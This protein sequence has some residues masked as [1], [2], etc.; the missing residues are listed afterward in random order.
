MASPRSSLLLLVILVVAGIATSCASGTAGPRHPPPARKAVPARHAVLLP[1]HRGA[2]RPVPAATAAA[3]RCPAASYGPSPSAPGG[4]RTVALTFDDGPGRTTAE[5]LAI[6]RR[7]HVPATFFNIGENE[8]DR[9]S[10]VGAEADAGEAIG[11]HTW[12]HPDMVGLSAG[13]QAAELD[14]ATGEQKSIVGFAP[15]VFRPPYNDYDA[16]RRQSVPCRRSFVSSAP[17]ATTSCGCNHRTLELTRRWQSS[18]NT[19]P[20]EGG[21]AL[22]QRPRR[23]TGPLHQ[24]R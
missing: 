19:R 9:R 20:Q 16:T 8:A 24:Q 17:T 22:R 15:C 11:N 6:L 4:G 23:A 5:V 2:N 3:R 10:L 18:R 7:Y 14:K 13:R 12:N 21:P 1:V